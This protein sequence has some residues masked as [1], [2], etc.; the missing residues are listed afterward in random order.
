[1][2]GAQQGLK[3]SGL[4][5]GAGIPASC[6]TGSRLGSGADWWRDP[7][8]HGSVAWPRGRYSGVVWP[9]WLRDGYLVVCGSGAELWP[10]AARG[11]ESPAEQSSSSADLW[12]RDLA[13]SCSYIRSWCGEAFH[14]LSL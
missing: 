13:A 7:G 12:G 11:A 14:D 6:G 10:G 8:G 1:V 2:A 3:G 4:Q 5:G 9:A